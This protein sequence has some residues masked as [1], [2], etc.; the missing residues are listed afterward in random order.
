MTRR[1]RETLG[2]G[3]ES[4]LTG[5]TLDTHSLNP[6]CGSII[7]SNF[8]RSTF[9]LALR[10]VPL[11][12]TDSICF[13]TFQTFLFNGFALLAH[14]GT[15]VREGA[16]RTL[17]TF[18]HIGRSIELPRTFFACLNIIHPLDLMANSALF[19][20][21]IYGGPVEKLE[22][23]RIWLEAGTVLTGDRSRHGVLPLIII[24]EFTVLH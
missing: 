21:A 24:A 12:V 6:F 3:R 2:L 10:S 5:R 13:R 9:A 14:R 8:T 19:T 23:I 17:L 4:I 15:L 11:E 20:A 7:Q 1:A 16:D 18:E 22:S